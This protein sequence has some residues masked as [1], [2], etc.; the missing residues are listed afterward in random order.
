MPSQLKQSTRPN[1]VGAVTE[2]KLPQVKAEVLRDQILAT[3]G[4]SSLDAQATL[5]ILAAAL[6]AESEDGYTR[7]SALGILQRARKVSTENLAAAVQKLTEQMAGAMT[8]FWSAFIHE[9][10]QSQDPP[11]QY[12][13]PGIVAQ[14]KELE[15]QEQEQNRKLAMQYVNNAQVAIAALSIDDKEFPQV[16]EPPK[17]S[18]LKLDV[19]KAI[20]NLIYKPVPA[21]AGPD[22]NAP[23]GWLTPPLL[24]RQAEDVT[25]FDN[26]IM[27][28]VASRKLSGEQAWKKLEDRGY[29]RQ[30]ILRAIYNVRRTAQDQIAQCDQ[31]LSFIHEDYQTHIEPVVKAAVL[32]GHAI[33]VVNSFYAP[34]PLSP[35]AEDVRTR[36][37][38][39]APRAK[40]R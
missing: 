25:V 22:P 15:E 2:Q 3:P 36:P 8:A 14:R 17:K 1:A 39:P 33:S 19:G 23:P 4:L 13:D 26:D 9:T 16:Q 12:V 29:D 27:D 38:P 20:H 7:D 24:D 28:I 40:G 34:L 30:R 21:K 32:L 37:G 18:G 31:I 11:P 10:W 6:L 5:T 35:D